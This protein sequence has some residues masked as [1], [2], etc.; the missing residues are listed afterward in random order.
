MCGHVVCDVCNCL[1]LSESWAPGAIQPHVIS[2]EARP[3]HS[4]GHGLGNETMHGL[5]SSDWRIQ[6]TGIIV[7]FPEIGPSTALYPLA[8]GVTGSSCF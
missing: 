6:S 5:C 4:S 2:R 8:E 3:E 1:V 7:C